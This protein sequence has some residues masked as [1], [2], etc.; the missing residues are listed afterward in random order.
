MSSATRNILTAVEAGADAV[1][2]RS[3]WLGIHVPDSCPIT[4]SIRRN[5]FPLDKMPKA[6]YSKKRGLGSN[7]AHGR[8]VQKARHV[9]IILVGYVTPEAGE[10]CFG[11]A[12]PILSA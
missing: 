9:P 7:E 8:G 12:G 3:H 1:M 5:R 11:R 2:I 10:R 4:C 6:Y